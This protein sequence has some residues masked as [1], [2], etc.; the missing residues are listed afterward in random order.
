MN[1]SVS[2]IEPHVVIFRGENLHA[3][4]LKH[5][6]VLDVFKGEDLEED[7]RQEPIN[8]FNNVSD[9]HEALKLLRTHH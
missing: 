1:W 6:K 9:G 3:I 8:T 4:L 5:A 7:I 2:H